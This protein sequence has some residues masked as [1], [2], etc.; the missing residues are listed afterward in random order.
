MSSFLRTACIVTTYRDRTLT[1]RPRTRACSIRAEWNGVGYVDLTFGGAANPSE[2]FTL[3][4]GFPLT[5][6]ALRRELAA[7]IR[8]EDEE[9]LRWQLREFC[10]T[11][12]ERDELR[13]C[14]AT[15]HPRNWLRLYIENSR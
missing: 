1:G 5:R 10:T 8:D 14:Y 4:D 6:G 3:P 15:S 7:W 12:D 9:E 11:D 13:E 2:V